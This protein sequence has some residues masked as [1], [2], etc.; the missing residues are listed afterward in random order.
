MT[1][2]V[3]SDVVASAAAI[4][5]TPAG[6]ATAMP[7]VKLPVFSAEFGSAACTARA[8][9]NEAGETAV[10][11]VRSGMIL[12]KTTIEPFCN[13]VTSIRDSGTSSAAAVSFAKPALN[14]CSF[15]GVPT[16]SSKSFSI[17]D[18]TFTGVDLMRAFSRS[19]A[20]KARSLAS[21]V[22]FDR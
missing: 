11:D 21:S 19:S 10:V 18:V 5:S 15:S 3:V 4:S 17:L 8:T 22:G 6:N 9:A 2:S 1:P 12:N 13:S 14:A 16:T 20:V 7:D